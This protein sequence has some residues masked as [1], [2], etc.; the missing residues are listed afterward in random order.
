MFKPCFVV[1]LIHAAASHFGA[2][3]SACSTRFSIQRVALK[4]AALAT[5]CTSSRVLRSSL[6]LTF[7][8]FGSKG[9]FF[10]MA[11]DSIRGCASFAIH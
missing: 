1:I 10:P 7:G 2:L 8:L 4:P 5:A 9:K 6:T 11:F 3:P